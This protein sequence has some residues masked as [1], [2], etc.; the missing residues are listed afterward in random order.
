M[1]IARAQG[2]ERQHAVGRDRRE[3]M[4][5]E[6][7]DR[8]PQRRQGPAIVADVAVEQALAAA[9][10]AVQRR[11]ARVRC[12]PPG[13]IEQAQALPGRGVPTQQREADGERGPLGS[14]G[15]GPAH[16][17]QRPGE[18]LGGREPS[19][20]TVGALPRAQ[21]PGER[22]GIA[23]LPKVVRDRVGF[24]HR[25]GRE[26]GRHA[27]VPA[28]A[29][30]REDRRVQ[31]LANQGVDEAGGR[32]V[33]RLVQDARRRRPLAQGA[34]G[35]LVRVAHPRPEV[36]R[37]LLADDRRDRQLPARLITQARQPHVDQLAEEGRDVRGAEIAH[38]PAVT[39]PDERAL[40]D[41]RAEQFPEVEGGA[42]CPPREIGE[43][44]S[45]VGLGQRVPLAHVGP[46]R[47]VPERPQIQAHRP[48]LAHQGGQV[49]VERVLA[50]QIIA[51]VGRHHE[52]RQRGEVATHQ[53][54]EI[55]AGRVGPVEIV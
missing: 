10:R 51:A 37:H 27:A 18:A 6:D 31:R 32:P 1:K 41:E 35:L 33:R 38:G 53:P 8:L 14:T 54:E 36:E 4:G 3:G 24:G 25:R 43:E 26:H 55:Q 22:L 7:D 12:Q 30:R 39:R 52:D 48:T 19:V 45:R 11:A 16:E 47:L 15:L 5:I 17:F 21:Q 2:V 13:L 23:R 49:R 29:L 28:T 40:V 9:R 20:G 50:G 46:H 42:L 34:Q 44:P